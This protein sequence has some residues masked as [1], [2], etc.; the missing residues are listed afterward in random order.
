[1]LIPLLQ[2]MYP[3]PA[4]ASSSRRYMGTLVRRTERKQ[5]QVHCRD[6]TIPSSKGLK[7]ITRRP[8]PSNSDIDRYAPSERAGDAF[9]DP[10]QGVISFMRPAT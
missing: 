6:S 8:L 7:P 1:M 10:P 9:G 3:L 2:Q 4:K 5:A